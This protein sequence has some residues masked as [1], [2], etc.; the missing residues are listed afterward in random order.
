MRFMVVLKFNEMLR[1]KDTWMA[2]MNSPSSNE[3][4]QEEL[5]HARHSMLFEVYA[6]NYIVL[7]LGTCNF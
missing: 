3:P 4:T 5:Q 6:A 2:N 1:P 7:P